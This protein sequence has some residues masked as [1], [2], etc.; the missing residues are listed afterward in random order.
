VQVVWRGGAVDVAG[1]RFEA[2][3]GA[4]VNV[5]TVDGFLAGGEIDV[6]HDGSLVE[7]V[8]LLAPP[9]G[10]LLSRIATITDVHVGEPRFGLL[11]SYQEPRAVKPGYAVRCAAAA[12]GEAAAW[13]AEL[14]V[15]RGDLTWTG[16]AAQWEQVA[17]VLGASPVP[18]VAV[19]GNHDCTK[20]GVE[21]RPWLEAAGV[22]VVDEHDEVGCVDVAGLRIVLVHTPVRGERPGSVPPDRRQRAVA[23]AKAAPAGSGVLLVMHHYPD[24]HPRPTRY[25]RGTPHRD[26]LAL[27]QAL[28]PRTLVAPGHSHR[29]RRY[30]LGGIAVAETGSTKDYPGVWAGMAVHEGGL[31]QVVRRVEASGAI[32]W[33]ERTGGALAGWYGRWTPG[34]RSARCFTYPWP[35]GGRG[36]SGA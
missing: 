26:A 14:I 3:P 17:E 7:R 18:V 34:R 21:G 29:H 2:D 13:G 27:L 22:R 1:R 19:L 33:T 5:A 4:R 6:R 8:Q 12:V 24:R 16:R 9:P 36:A 15:V 31:R 35:A 25:P 32:E 28:P 30:T 11:P 10:Q 23:L 20:K